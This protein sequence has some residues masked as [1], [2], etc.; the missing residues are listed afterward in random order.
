M[1]GRWSAPT[2]PSDCW[3]AGP[4]AWVGWLEAPLRTTLADRGFA[5]AEVL[6]QWARRGWLVVTTE[7]GKSRQ[8]LKAKLDGQ[9]TWLV[10]LSGPQIAELTGTGDSKQD[11]GKAPG[12]G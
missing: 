2:V 8:K 6:P 12:A 11:S 5:L 7:K 10:A 3:A 4:G 1:W 9:N